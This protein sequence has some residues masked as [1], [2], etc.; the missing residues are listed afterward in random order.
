[1]AVGVT[2]AQKQITKY[3]TACPTGKMVLTSYP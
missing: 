2:N 1:M 3:Y